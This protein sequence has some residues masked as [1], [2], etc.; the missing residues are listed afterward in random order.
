MKKESLDFLKVLKENNNRDWFLAN[1]KVYEA[2]KADFTAFVTE[3]LSEMS[4]FDPSLSG[5]EAKSCLFRINRDV[6]FSKDKSP[7]KINMSAVMARGGKNMQ[8]PGMYVHFQPG[9][10]FVAGGYWMPQPEHLKAI[11]QEIDYNAE[12]FKQILQEKEFVQLYKGLEEEEGAKLKTSPKE[13]S[14][15]HPEIEL[16]KFKSYVVSAPVADNVFLETS[17]AKEVA[18]LFKVMMPFKVFL[19]QAVGVDA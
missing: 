6:R 7:Y 15:D 9:G 8:A 13:Y 5:V 18:Q 2:A 10:C 1:K 19:E 17:A 11:R 16:L 14:K 4:K 3:L 12:A